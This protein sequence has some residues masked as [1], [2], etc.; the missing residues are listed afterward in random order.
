MLYDFF[1]NWSIVALQCCVSSAVQQSKSAICIHISPLPWIS[2][3]FRSPQNIE[4]PELYSRFSLCI[5]SLSH[6]W[7][8]GTPWTAACQPPLSMGFSRQEYWSGLL[9][10]PSGDLPSSGIKHSSVYMLIPIPP[11]L[12][13]LGI[14]T[15]V[16]YICISISLEISS[17]ISFL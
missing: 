10:P 11:P 14:H 9:H 17:S 16:L 12:F 3:P 2:F 6:V 8:F 1:F 4:F 13:L 5:K 15:F 7:L